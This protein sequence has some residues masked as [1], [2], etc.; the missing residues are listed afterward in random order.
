MT[1]GRDLRQHR[2]HHDVTVTDLAKHL[3]VSRQT[4]HN[5]EKREDQID[6]VLVERYESAVRDIATVGNEE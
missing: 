4:V 2:R 1:T 3:G 5:W 6:P